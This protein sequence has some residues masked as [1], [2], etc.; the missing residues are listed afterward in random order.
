MSFVCPT[1]PAEAAI[2]SAPATH[3]GGR[4]RT[5]VLLLLVQ[6][7]GL[8]RIVRASTDAHPVVPVEWLWAAAEPYR[9]AIG[10][11]REAVAAFLS[12][13]AKSEQ[14]AVIDL[15]R[16]PVLLIARTLDDRRT[17]PDRRK[18]RRRG[19]VRPP[20]KG[21]SPRPPASSERRPPDATERP[22]SAVHGDDCCLRGNAM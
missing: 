13:E 7:D 18:R 20:A 21:R 3:Q 12:A 14:R 2:V 11:V 19:R 16:V 17:T 4:S 5:P 1:A 8:V 22:R 10:S 15:D 9:C 6:Q